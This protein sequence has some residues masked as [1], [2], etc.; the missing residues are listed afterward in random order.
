MITVLALAVIVVLVTYAVIVC[1]DVR[2]ESMARGR[3]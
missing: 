3:R 2:A 1:V